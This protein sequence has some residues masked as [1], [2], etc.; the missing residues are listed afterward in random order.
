MKGTRLFTCEGCVSFPSILKSKAK[1][2]MHAQLR[3]ELMK[4]EV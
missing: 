4:L 3:C 1:K 2:K